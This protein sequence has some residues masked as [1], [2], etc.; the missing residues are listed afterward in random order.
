MMA[1][2]SSAAAHRGVGA[3][4]VNANGSPAGAAM[5]MPGSQVMQ[6]GGTVSKT[7]IV[8]RVENGGFYI[9]YALGYPTANRVRVWRVG[10]STA[11]LLARTDANSQ[12]TLS[13]DP[14]GRI[15]AVWSDGTFG[16]T[17]VL[18]AR[19]NPEATRFGAH[20]DAGAV[21]GAHLTYSVDASATATALDVFTPLGTGNESGGATYVKRIRPGLTLKARKRAGSVTF[22][23]T[24]A[25][26]AVRGATVRSG[27]RSGRTNRQGRVTLKFKRGKATASA[28]G[29][30]PAKLKIK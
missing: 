8:A 4:A 3:Q 14:K 9:A 18:A 29:Y 15:W 26:D 21:G 20:V 16:E 30:A 28:Q 25:G 12:V 5:T 23:V 1:W 13:A 17:H 22:T 6:G 27:G 7:P 19:S 11:R 10:A 2:F 24:D